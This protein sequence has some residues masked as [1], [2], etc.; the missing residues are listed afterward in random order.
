MVIK[1]P[2]A[3][4][5]DEL[6]EKLTKQFPDYDVSYIQ[7]KVLLVKKSTTVGAMINLKKKNIKIFGDFGTVTARLIFTILILLLGVIIPLIVFLIVFMPKQNKFR[8]EIANFVK[9]E[10]NLQ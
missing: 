5:V 1:S 8:D 6:Y 3:I 2:N 4:N 9:K 10:Y 7:K